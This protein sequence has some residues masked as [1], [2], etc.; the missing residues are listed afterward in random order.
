M[1][2]DPDVFLTSRVWIMTSSKRLATRK[3]EWGRYWT[4]GTRRW[5]AS[6]AGQESAALRRTVA[7]AASASGPT[8]SIT[9]PRCIEGL[10]HPAPSETALGWFCDPLL[11]VAHSEL[12]SVSDARS[13]V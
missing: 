2:L 4:I 10:G 1:I 11:N 3:N 12:K 7:K 8:V 13:A 5:S 9:V 6:V